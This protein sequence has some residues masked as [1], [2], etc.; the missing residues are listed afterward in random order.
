MTTRWC[1]LSSVFLFTMRRQARDGDEDTW[2]WEEELQMEKK[3]FLLCH[4]FRRCLEIKTCPSSNP[5]TG[6]SLQSTEDPNRGLA[7]IAAVTASTSSICPEKK[8]SWSLQYPIS[9][10]ERR[11]GGVVG[12][13]PLSFCSVFVWT[14]SLFL[15]LYTTPDKVALSLC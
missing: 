5:Q 8:M 10:C 3:G 4:T 12:E 13:N 2:K 11:S 15:S 1:F 14:P 6:S 7:V 9:G